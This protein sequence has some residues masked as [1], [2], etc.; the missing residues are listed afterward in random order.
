MCGIIGMFF[1]PSDKAESIRK[2]IAVHAITNLLLST[3]KRGSDATGVVAINKNGSAILCKAPVKAERFILEQ[4]YASGDYKKFTEALEE[5]ND[6]PKIILGHCRKIS[7]GL[8]TNDYNHPH[9]VNNSVGVHNGT[10]LNHNI[11]F[12][13]LGITSHTDSDSLAIVTLFDYYMK[14]NNYVMHKELIE[15]LNRR[16]VGSYAVLLTNTNNPNQIACMRSDRPVELCYLKD[17]GVLVAASEKTFFD[18]LIHAL[19]LTRITDKNCAVDLGSNAVE[20]KTVVDNTGMIIN[21]TGGYSIDTLCETVNCSKV[22]IWAVPK[23]PLTLPYNYQGNSYTKAYDYDKYD[24]YDVKKEVKSEAKNENADTDTVKNTHVDV[25]LSRWVLCTNIKRYIHSGAVPE[26]KAD[27][28]L[29]STE[30]P[31]IIQTKSD[32]PA[33]SIKLI[34]H[35]VNNAEERQTIEIEKTSDDNTH[36]IHIVK[37]KI[38]EEKGNH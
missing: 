17:A 6:E 3:E 34:Q 25:Q 31:L 14:T 15:T 29:V 22:K 5:N 33:S 37:K 13:K 23:Q 28:K 8:K 9:I 35:S 24:K 16:F 4:D 20:Y 18:A 36:R 27:I 12:K 2:R 1:V 38:I 32:T 11:I 10:L 19:R 7:V 26:K 21:L 30:A